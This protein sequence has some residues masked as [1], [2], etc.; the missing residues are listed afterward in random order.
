MMVADMRL[1]WLTLNKCFDKQCGD[2]K[3]GYYSEPEKNPDMFSGFTYME[4]LYLV[5][6]N[7]V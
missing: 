1:M 3:H 4:N 5:Y 2:D 6:Y 7:H